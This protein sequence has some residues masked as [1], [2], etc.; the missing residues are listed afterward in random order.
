MK[1]Q[2]SLDIKEP[3]SKNYNQF[4]P[5]PN[6]GFCNSCTKEVID[7]TTMSAQET[8][9]YFKNNSSKTTC[10]R[11]NSY[12]LKTYEVPPKKSKRLSLLSGI[13][14]ACLSLF[15]F[16]TVQGQVIKKQNNTSEDDASKI[17]SQKHDKEFVVKGTVADETGPLPGVNIVLEGTR[18]G[19]S[20][21]FDGNFTFPEKLKKDDVLVFSFIGLESRKVVITNEDSA[22][23]VTLKVDMNLSTCVV[24]GKVAVKKVFKSKN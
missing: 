23:N 15:S 10:G 2:F 18:I 21:D 17:I 22:S 20:T 24:I 11:F 6:G 7:F 13:G 3:C 9:A 4:T 1:N 14:L 8:I 5:T 16:T 19:T 12:Q